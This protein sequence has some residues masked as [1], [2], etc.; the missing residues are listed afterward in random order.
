MMKARRLCLVTTTLI[1]LGL[2]T[3]VFAHCDSM[4]GP[5]IKDA[6]RAL[7]TNDVTPVLK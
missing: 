2:A 5:V 6:Q 1:S 3:Q 4:D 7:E